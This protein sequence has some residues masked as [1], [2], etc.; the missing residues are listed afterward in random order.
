LRS[1]ILKTQ[2][3]AVSLHMVH[4]LVSFFLGEMKDSRRN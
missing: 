4:E 2:V 3:F 1:G